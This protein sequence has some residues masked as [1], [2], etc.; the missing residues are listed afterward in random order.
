MT[1]LRIAADAGILWVLVALL[2]AA[3][4]LANW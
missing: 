1:A 4:T 2:C 3:W